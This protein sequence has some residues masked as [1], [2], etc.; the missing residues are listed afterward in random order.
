MP[1]GSEAEVTEIPST[2]RRRQMAVCREHHGPYVRRL[3]LGP[4]LNVW[5]GS[6]RRHT[7]ARID[8]AG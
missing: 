5:A 4:K 7:L 1:C 8:A 2:P 3:R 6:L